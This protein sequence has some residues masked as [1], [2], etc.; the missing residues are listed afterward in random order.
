MTDLSARLTQ[1]LAATPPV[2]PADELL[3]YVAR[4]Y[5]KRDL[6]LKLW[7]ENGGVPLYLFDEQALLSRAV[8]FRTAFE[9]Q[10]PAADFYYAMKSNNHPFLAQSLAAAGF[11][12]DVS[13]ALELQIALDTAAGHIVFSGPG[14]LDDE[15]AQAI[16]RADRVT[17]LIDSFG[18]L[19]RLAAMAAARGVCIRAGVRLNPPGP[20]GWRKF[21]VG[22]DRLRSFWETATERPGVQLQGIQFHTSWNMTSIAQTET[23]T[24]LGREIGSWPAELSGRI[25]FLD[26][27]GGYWPP[28]G[29]WLLPE[30]TD[31]GRIRQL[32][33][34]TTPD[35]S[36]HFRNP[37]IGIDEAASCLAKAIRREI[38]PITQCRVCFEPGRWLSNEAMHI[39]VSVVDKKEADLVITDAG[40]NAIGW[41][42]F[43]QDYA[44]VLNLSQP[45]MAEQQCHVL[46][47]LCTPHDVWGYSYFGAGIDRGDI[48]LIPDQGAYTYSLRQHFIKPV[49][50][51]VRM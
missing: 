49:P 43:E 1:M 23:I 10:F 16:D 28:N 29:E 32:L 24:A 45:A 48:P 9:A 37:A 46:G 2:L 38:F 11:G 27:G 39:M 3:R 42:R 4:H 44:P 40:T 36:V 26:I 5:E 34:G 25:A 15:H 21:G 19:D 35:R 51:V 7:R 22:L 41:E 6:C 18:E 13:S 12:L 33:D 14:K 47:S 20:H 17:V 8:Q 30:A 50:A 31:G